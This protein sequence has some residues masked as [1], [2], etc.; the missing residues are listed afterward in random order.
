MSNE[1]RGRAETVRLVSDEAG[2]ELWLE[3]EA[4][5][6]FGFNVHACAPELFEQVK[7]TIGAWLSEA[8]EVRQK[9]QRNGGM[10]P[11]RETPFAFVCDEIDESAGLAEVYD[12]HDPKNPQFHSVHVDLYDQERDK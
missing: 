12:L 3:N 9:R 10:L 11:T 4:G 5:E 1:Y 8:D 2:F 6:S 7:R